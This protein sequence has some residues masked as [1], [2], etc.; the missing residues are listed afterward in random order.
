MVAFTS[1]A[2]FVHLQRITIQ[3]HPVSRGDSN[4]KNYSNN[5]A[6]SI[7]PSFFQAML[8]DTKSQRHDST[9]QKNNY[10]HVL[11]CFNNEA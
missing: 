9:D 10:G 4:N 2:R 1:H 7:I 11:E 3:E 6:S 8:F 5:N